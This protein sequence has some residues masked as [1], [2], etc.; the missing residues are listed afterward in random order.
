[1]EAAFRGFL[2]AVGVRPQEAPQLTPHC[3]IEDAE[4]QRVQGT[5][6]GSLS[7]EM[8]PSILDPYSP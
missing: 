6:L 8:R 3:A 2:R 7:N 4:V 5:C 1:M